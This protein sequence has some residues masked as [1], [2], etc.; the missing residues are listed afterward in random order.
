MARS[1]LNQALTLAEYISQHFNDSQKAFADAQNVAPAQVTQ[2]LK[3]DFIVV[4]RV[5]YSKRR[6]LNP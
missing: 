6:N 5:L 3:K 1:K 4:D 2:W